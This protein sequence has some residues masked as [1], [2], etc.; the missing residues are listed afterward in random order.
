M[1][2]TEAFMILRYLVR[3][4]RYN[5]RRAKRYNKRELPRGTRSMDNSGRNSSFF[6]YREIRNEMSEI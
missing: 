1:N 3:A 6:P 4:K 5:V 2:K